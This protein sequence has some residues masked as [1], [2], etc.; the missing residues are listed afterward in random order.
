ME[1]WSNEWFNGRMHE[2]MKYWSNEL[3]NGIMK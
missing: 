3:I 1:E 2:R